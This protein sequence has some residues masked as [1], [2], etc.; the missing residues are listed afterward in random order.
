M[1]LESRFAVRG[2]ITT[3]VFAEH[4]AQ[5]VDH[6]RFATAVRADHA[7]Q[8]AGDMNRCGIYEGL[9]TRQLYLS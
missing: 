3:S 5:R 4:P 2:G 7:Y 6:V 1:R 9:K 8:L